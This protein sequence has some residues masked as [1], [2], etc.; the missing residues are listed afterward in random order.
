MLVALY[1]GSSSERVLTLMQPL[2]RAFVAV[3]QRGVRW[4]RNEDGSERGKHFTRFR[5][6]T[7]YLRIFPSSLLPPS[8]H[9]VTTPHSDIADTGNRPSLRPAEHQPRSRPFLARC[10]GGA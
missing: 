9:Y 2:L 8:L 10:C 6:Y 4:P 5:I 3:L 7:P 1:C